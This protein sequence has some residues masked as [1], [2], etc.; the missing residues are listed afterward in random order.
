[1]PTFRFSLFGRDL[2]VS[3]TTPLQDSGW[4]GLSNTVAITVSNVIAAAAQ[5]RI[6][7]SGRFPFAS[8]VSIDVTFSARIESNRLILQQATAANQANRIT[9]VRP[10]VADPNTTTPADLATFAASRTQDYF[11]DSAIGFLI[12]AGSIA[13]L[14][15]YILGF[16]SLGGL[17]APAGDY[18]LNDSWLAFDVPA[19]PSADAAA[20][21]GIVGKAE[22]IL[23]DHADA[24]RR[25]RLALEHIR[26]ARPPSKP[27]SWSL[28]LAPDAGYLLIGSDRLVKAGTAATPV[29]YQFAMVNGRLSVEHQSDGGPAVFQNSWHPLA[30][31][32]QSTLLALRVTDEH[33]LPIALCADAPFQVRPRKGAGGSSVDSLVLTTPDQAAQDV[34]VY[35]VDLA[36]LHDD[37]LLG[38]DTTIPVWMTDS[39][40]PLLPAAPLEMHGL[41]RGTRLTRPAAAT[42]SGWPATLT[43]IAISRPRGD[44]PA[45]EFAELHLTAQPGWRVA[46]Q[47]P[48]Q[49]VFPGNG[50]ILLPEVVERSATIDGGALALPLM[51]TIWSLANLATTGGTPA[52]AVAATTVQTVLN[53]LRALDGQFCDPE[54]GYALATL[55][56]VVGLP[57]LGDGTLTAFAQTGGARGRVP[58]SPDFHRLFSSLNLVA[59][60][61]KFTAQPLPELKSRTATANRALGF[62]ATPATSTLQYLHGGNADPGTPDVIAR[63]IDA[64][65]PFGSQYQGFAKAWLQPSSQQKAIFE[66]LRD[67][68]NLDVL[69]LAG[70]VADAIPAEALQRAGR[71]AEDAAAG[72]LRS[73]FDDSSE[74]D[75]LETLAAWL[76]ATPPDL[77]VAEFVDFFAGSSSADAAFEWV[78]RWWMAP[79][80]QDLFRRLVSLFNTNKA[81]LDAA[82]PGQAQAIAT[83]LFGQ[84]PIPSP[85]TLGGFLSE[86]MDGPSPDFTLL[87]Q[88]WQAGDNGALQSILQA[89]GIPAADVQMQRVLDLFA[90]LRD[91]LGPVLTK[92]VYAKLLALKD[93]AAAVLAVLREELQRKLEKLADIVADPP[94]Y[95]VISRRLGILPP[96]RG[97]SLWSH[98]FDGCRQGAIPWFWF[99][100]TD[101]TIVVKTSTRRS[102]ADVLRELNSSYQQTGRSNPLAVPDGDLASYIDAIEPEVRD[103]R[104]WIGI[105]IIKP[106]FDLSKDLVVSALTGLNTIEALYVALGGARPDQGAEGGPALDVIARIRKSAPPPDPKSKTD[107]RDADLSL[108]KFD[109]T[110]RNTTIAEGEIACRLNL[111]E[112]FGQTKKVDGQTMLIQAVLPPAKVSDPARAFE[113]GCYFDTPLVVPV[114]IMFIKSVA[115]RSLKAVRHGGDVAIDIDADV[116]L[117]S[118]HLPVALGDF[119]Q[120]SLKDFRIRI[121]SGGPTN[122]LMGVARSVSFDFPALSIRLPAARTLNLSGLDI[123]PTGLGFLRLKANEIS[124]ELSD[125]KSRFLGIPIPGFNFKLQDLVDGD[126]SLPTVNMRLDLGNLPGLGGGGGFELDIVMGMPVAGGVPDFSRLF[127]GIGGFEAKHLKIDLFRFI[128]LEIDDLLFAND[129]TAGLGRTQNDIGMLLAEKIQLKILDWS[130]LDNNDNL[131]LAYLNYADPKGGSDKSWLVSLQT[132]PPPDAFLQIYGLVLAKGLEFD[133]GFYNMLLGSLDNAQS[134]IPGFVDK[135]NKKIKANVNGDLPWLMALTFGLRGILDR[136]AFVLQDGKYYGIRLSAPWIKTVFDLDSLSL[137][138]IPGPTRTQDRFRIAVTIPK[139]DMIANMRSGEIALEWAVNQDFLVDVGF[140]WLDS[141]GYNWFRAFSVPAGAYEVKFGF[142]FEKRTHVEAEQETVTFAA[143]FAI[144]VGYFFGMGNGVAWLRAG[145]GVFAVLQAK[146][147]V[148]L[149]ARVTNIS[150]LPNVVSRVEIVGAIGIFAYGEGGID[151]WVLSA[152]FRLSAQASV[153]VSILVVRGQPTAL[154][155][156]VSLAVGYS[157]SVRIGCGFCSWTFSVSGTLSIPISGRLMLG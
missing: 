89:L 55:P 80:D 45:Y 113:F 140:P 118:D 115:F 154:S 85:D 104:E 147:T 107:L 103:K 131:S 122:I 105:F 64:G 52:S 11:G 141:Q 151:I 3:S 109:V 100:D 35:A 23:K 155:Y 144:Y 65:A 21:Y 96:G 69:K 110:I 37:R 133:P 125:L 99:L 138:Y 66:A 153:T 15:T 13:G 102:M 128:T 14:T 75:Q 20:L 26:K 22:L 28:R 127:V 121:P 117:Q 83:A 29:L 51:D 42:A 7:L 92:D 58:S 46:L 1:M 101:T 129:Y 114:D 63:A 61:P 62:A 73:L 70:F 25:Q 2:S 5:V 139:L 71:L 95:F 94:E 44:E 4:G 32:G 148:D 72:A 36:Q 50:Q 77:I 31:K 126:Y 116:A 27:C 130:P 150:D 86:V 9:M 10:S 106:T 30:T 43:T 41:A 33:G 143:G 120:V 47:L 79:P 24:S 54:P 57:H 39:G 93:E 135:A 87:A 12:R 108:V 59:P 111:V 156:T 97:D 134:V 40:V 82:F 76:A 157:A 142:Y 119:P 6:V 84:I 38:V 60:T 146:L 91:Q 136:C 74:T 8:S 48:E 34:S 19:G 90:S 56:R 145:I 124:A 17:L 49:S 53:R 18:S 88:L 78:A 68:L 149:R 67:K 98:S 81:W 137:A 16:D 152:R 132:R 123:I 112:L